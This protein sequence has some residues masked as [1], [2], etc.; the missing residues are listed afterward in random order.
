M[1]NAEAGHH[2]V[3]T[4]AVSSEKEVNA[5]LEVTRFATINN[6]SDGSSKIIIQPG[7]EEVLASLPTH[8]EGKSNISQLMDGQKQFLEQVMGAY[9]AVPNRKVLEEFQQRVRTLQSTQ[10]LLKQV[11]TVTTGEKFKDWQQKETTLGVVKSGLDKPTLGRS[12][13]VLRND[14]AN[15]M[16]RVDA[17]NTRGKGEVF[18]RFT[19]LQTGALELAKN[20]GEPDLEAAAPFIAHMGEA[21]QVTR[22]SSNLSAEKKKQHAQVKQIYLESCRKAYPEVKAEIS[23]LPTHLE[24]MVEPIGKLEDWMSDREL[25]QYDDPEQ[26]TP[27]AFLAE[28]IENVVSILNAGKST[29]E[30]TLSYLHGIRR[31]VIELTTIRS[32]DATAEY[33]DNNITTEELDQ[34]RADLNQLNEFAYTLQLYIEQPQTKESPEQDPTQRYNKIKEELSATN[35]RGLVGRMESGLDPMGMVSVSE[36]KAAMQPVLDRAGVDPETLNKFTADLHM[37]GVWNNADRLAASTDPEVKAWMLLAHLTHEVNDHKLT[38]DEFLGDVNRIKTDLAA[39]QSDPQT[40]LD[41]A[42][43]TIHERAKRAFTKGEDGIPVTEEDGFLY[44]AI[45]GETA[46]V[47]KQGE[48]QFVGANELDYEK[49]AQQFGLKKEVRKDERRGG[50]D[51]TFYVGNNNTEVKALGQGFCIVFGGDESIA[52]ALAKTGQDNAAR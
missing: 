4:P 47:M 34:I 37:G 6:E 8:I 13:E 21:E 49:V 44:M 29:P 25:E 14:S 9:D 40:A 10:E 30:A 42:T 16:K 51:T 39:A 38:M 5:A 11:Q 33:Y 45:E 12:L 17:K 32:E 23:V 52:K 28:G 48:L 15:E 36:V 19:T 1:N 26:R 50:V 24:Q 43:H 22:M 20:Q 46:G 3:F 18:H 7:V 35:V 27:R 41:T 2:E 31:T